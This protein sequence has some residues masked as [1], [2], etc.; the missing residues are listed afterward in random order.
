LKNTWLNVFIDE[1]GTNDLDYSKEGTSRLFI[2]VAVTVD[3]DG[4][5]E[6]R[7]KITELSNNLCSG[8]EIKSSNIGSKHKRRLKFLEGIKALPFGY[9][10]LVIDKERL[11][12]DSGFRFKPSFYKCLN[13]MLYQ[14]L[15]Q[16]GADIRVIAD[17]I[18]G[19]DFMDS[20]APYLTRH[21][22][23]S[24]FS[25]FEHSFVL[26]ES[27]PMVQLADLIAGTLGYCFEPGK[28]SDFSPVYRAI[29]AEKEIAI[30]SWPIE[31]RTASN[32][33]SSHGT[34]WT[35]KF[36]LANLN[37]A[38][39]F[40][41]EHEQSEDFDRRMQ[42]TVLER[43]MFQNEFEDK[44]AQPIRSD[45]LIKMLELSGFE[46]LSRQSLSSRVIGKVRDA[47]ILISGNA[48]GYRLATDVKDIK[49]FVQ[50][51]RNI[52]EPML[53]RLQTARESVKQDTA[54]RFDILSEQEFST[55]KAIAET[56]KEAQFEHLNSLAET[57]QGK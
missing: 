5:N 29:L 22:L 14:K 50:H 15:T 30:K 32:D 13:R 31:P 1:T 47:G 21:G 28:V 10:A 40:I 56:F 48:K 46:K 24:L 23:P 57:S 25:R 4:V 20:F 12:K 8:A 52:L 41:N 44:S 42:V 17:E 3:G 36:K 51:N 27:E 33:S 11:P 7:Q 6:A 53:G 18:G 49:S 9:M 2:C 43:L 55:L 45:E 35:H 19:R 54:N 16:G 26:S 38:L 34:D 39:K 37:R